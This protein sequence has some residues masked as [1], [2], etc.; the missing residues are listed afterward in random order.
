[1]LA[2]SAA[3]VHFGA[4]FTI[5]AAVE[6]STMAAVPPEI[7]AT[8]VIAFA[9]SLPELIVSVRSAMQGRPEVAV[10]NVIGSNIFNALG[11]VGASALFGTLVVPASLTS[12]ALPL[13]LGTTIL[14]FFV[15]QEHEM[16]RWD[17]W[18]LLILYVGFVIEL[19][20][21]G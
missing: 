4:H 7:I 17:G 15:L 19:V 13:M 5:E 3:G 20:G 18:L 2:L 16:T 12:F 10:G 9:T 11:V 1:M 14:C 21:L 8:S 6:I